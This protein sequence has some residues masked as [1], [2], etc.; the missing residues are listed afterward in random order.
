M[1]VLLGSMPAES[2]PVALFQA[3]RPASSVAENDVAADGSVFSFDLA[4]VI[5]SGLSFSALSGD[6]ALTARDT[7]QASVAESPDANTDAGAALQPATAP[8][9]VPM[10]WLNVLSSGLNAASEPDAA[11]DSMKRGGA[12]AVEMASS[13]ASAMRAGVSPASVESADNGGAALPVPENV[14]LPVIP[15]VMTRLPQDEALPAR[16]AALA[17]PADATFLATAEADNAAVLPSVRSGAQSTLAVGQKVEAGVAPSSDLGF[18]AVSPFSSISHAK[19]GESLVKLPGGDSTQW[20]EPLR[21]AL[22]ERLQFQSGTATGD[23]AVIRLDPPQMGRIEIAIRHEAG[24]LTVNLSATH[25]E[26]LR[27]LQGIGEHL[28]QDLVQR[29]QGDVSVTVAEASSARSGSGEPGANPHSR[30]G[31]G[32]GSDSEPGRALDEA[33][34]RSGTPAFRMNGDEE[35]TA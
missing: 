17:E 5:D 24:A 12:L 29:H 11:A 23:N 26:V 35:Q 9:S 25:S 16:T 27:Q 20:R 18:S 31:Q 4:A 32:K 14:A 8:S 21:Q 28:R 22:G 33:D 19:A 30:G 1:T 13:A 34:S 3:K 7:V 15:D 2:A 10:P 6:A